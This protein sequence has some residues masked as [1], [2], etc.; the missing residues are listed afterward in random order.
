[1]RSSSATSLLAVLVVIVTP[2][3]VAQQQTNAI[4]PAAKSIAMAAKLPAYD[5]VSIHQ[6]KTV[7]D[8]NSAI[9]DD[10]YTCE[11]CPLST[12]IQ[13]AYNLGN[14][15]QITGLSGPIDTARFDIKAK[16]ATREGSLP[17]KFTDE[18]LQ[19][20]VIPLLADRFHLRVRLVPKKMTVY[21]I[22]VAK[23]G[24]KFKLSEPEKHE[25]SGSVGFSGNDN[26]L[27]LKSMSLTGLADIISESTLHSIV[28][29]RTGLKGDADF[30]LKWTTDSALQQGGADAVSIFTAIQDQLGLKLRAVKLPVDTL[31]ID[32]A[33]MPTEN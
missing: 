12:L 27:T 14:L 15:D 33:E 8:S 13:D 6:N 22:V 1:M 23:G 18:Q 32:H 2:L 24:P 3:A 17:T 19:A 7:A 16:L 4:N 30:T 11:G 5:V 21:E 9:T 28:V 10:G 20:M 25:G 31:V 29:N 26:V